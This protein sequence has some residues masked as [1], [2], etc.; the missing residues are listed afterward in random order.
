METRESRKTIN[1]QRIIS[2]SGNSGGGVKNEVLSDMPRGKR[3]QTEKV[4]RN[5]N[6]GEPRSKEFADECKNAGSKKGGTQNRRAAR[7]KSV[8]MPQN[9][10]VSHQWISGLRGVQ[11]GL[12]AKPWPKHPGRGRGNPSGALEMVS[13]TTGP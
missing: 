7:H 13:R 9:I 3:G 5:V 11:K 2:N 6:N 12:H 10:K 4:Q 8:E 1:T